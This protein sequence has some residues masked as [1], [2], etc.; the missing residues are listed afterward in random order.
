MKYVMLFVDA[1]G[2]GIDVVGSEVESDQPPLVPEVGDRVSFAES[3][4]VYTV[5]AREF[6]YGGP[7]WTVI[8]ILEDA[9]RRYD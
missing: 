1:G 4:D 9:G 3:D 6:S 8:V 2:E 5:V 7:D